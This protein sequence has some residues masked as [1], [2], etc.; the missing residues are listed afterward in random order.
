MLT[1]VS[2]LELYEMQETPFFID[3]SLQQQRGQQQT[4]RI[5]IILER[6]KVTKL[7]NFAT[8]SKMENVVSFITICLQAWTKETSLFLAEKFVGLG[9]TAYKK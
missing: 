1:T 4:V 3:D 5:L 8:G 2:R 9:Y 6:S 7:V